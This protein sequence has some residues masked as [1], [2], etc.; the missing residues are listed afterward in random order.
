MRYDKDCCSVICDAHELCFF[1]KRCGDLGSIAPIVS[2]LDIADG[3]MYYKIQSEA[4]AYY[5]PNVELSL[6]S[7]LGDIYF[8]L[9][10][11]AD[12]II[13]KDGILTVDKIKAVK[14]RN[15]YSPPDELTL[16]LLKI[17]CHLLCVR[18]GLEAVNARV[19]YYNTESKKTKYF[20]YRYTARELAEFYSELLS[21]I[22]FRARSVFSRTSTREELATARF[23]YSELREGQEIMI[24]EGFS[25]IKKGRRVFIEAPTGTGKTISALFPAVRALGEGYCDKIF[26]L[27]PKTA[28]RKEAFS[29]MA[30]LYSSGTR[31]KTVI[32]TAKEQICPCATLINGKK[33][34]CTG[35]TCEYARGYYDR[36][37][38]ALQEILSNYTGF[39]RSL[40]FEVAMRHKVCPYELSLDLSE[41][42]DVVICDYNYVFDP[43][44][45]FRR[46]FGSDAIGGK[47]TFLIDEAHNLV[48]R[49]RETYSSELSRSDFHNIV[50]EIDPIDK[51]SV[52]SLFGFVEETFSP[53]K[54]LCKETLT[55][56]SVGNEAGFYIGNEP[57][58]ALNK[59]LERFSKSAKEFL[60]KNPE[61]Y[62]YEAIN[63]LLFKVKKYLTVI[64]YFDESF[65][66]YVKVEGGDITAKCYCLDPSD[67]LDSLLCRA[68][69][70]L[71]FSATLTPPEYFCSVLGGGKKAKTVSLPSPFDPDRLCVAVADYVN[72]RFEDRED[73]AKRFATVIAA[74]VKSR[75][76]NYIAY[77]P[78]YKCLEDTY[79]S[80]SK[81]YPTVECVV[82]KKNMT[83]A[84]REEFLSAF[85]EDSGK[86]RV[87]FC[88]LGGV[89]AEGVDLPGSRLIGSIIF[90]VGLPALSNE[91][92]IIRE[93]YD[94]NSDEGIGY[95]YSYTFPGMNNVL[96]AAGRVIRRADDVGLVVLADDRYATPKYRELFPEH[97]KDVKYAGN[98]SSLA[99]IMRRFWEKYPQE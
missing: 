94:Q 97:W 6:T 83:V 31:L 54:K 91:K 57:N 53:L 45:Y 99:E 95:D 11:R 8:T 29:A 23:P 1:A 55:V 26:Y 66:F 68:E 15:V 85:K 82:Q 69:S 13:R 2:P 77:F 40:I 92:N 89:F 96:Q 14:G 44:V 10:A 3:K 88:V 42:C 27:T 75:K 25:A 58:G 43:I 35:D 21:K 79:R 76:G 32:I 74:S 70:A 52:A 33:R 5:N 37:D 84:K 87:G 34:P 64:E 63:E 72:T 67:I 39:S 4:G 24:R 36:I 48:D 49:A 7:S 38:G 71:L 60:R 16:S 93:Y 98:A 59:A 17:S 9:N 81:K 78:S 19:T 86:L 47:Y 50:S 18:D 51:S 90:G 65:R 12:G 20:Y 62:L 28:T 41:L 61:H 30:R 22:E 56:D 73:N 80:F 46:Y